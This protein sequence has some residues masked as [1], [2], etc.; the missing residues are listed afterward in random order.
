MWQ[1]AETVQTLLR[2][3]HRL[4]LSAPDPNTNIFFLSITSYKH[5]LDTRTSSLHNPTPDIL[6]TTVPVKT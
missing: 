6:Y 4:P 3:K 2:P 5:V 1:Q